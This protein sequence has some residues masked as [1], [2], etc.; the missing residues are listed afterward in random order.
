MHRRW[1]IGVML[2]RW[3]ILPLVVFF[4]LS[5][6]SF[7]SAETAAVCTARY[8]NCIKYPVNMNERGRARCEMTRY[9]CLG[10][11]SPLPLIHTYCRAG[12]DN[13]RRYKDDAYCRGPGYEKCVLDTQF[14]G[15]VRDHR[16]K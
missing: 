6:I 7:A 8:N 9:T 13:C 10:Q 15:N 4:T 2:M 3:L 14:G 16:K 1:Y 5:P 11:R 12:Y